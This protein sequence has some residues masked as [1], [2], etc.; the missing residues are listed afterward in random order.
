MSPRSQAA[1][2][3]EIRRLVS[4]L[5]DAVP[6]SDALASSIRRFRKGDILMR[7]GEVNNAIFIILEG[8]AQ[9]SKNYGT[10]NSLPVGIAEPGDFVG[11]I[12]FYSTEAVFS[13]V[14]ART[15]VSALCLTREEFDRL[16]D[17]N[18][19]LHGL[20]QQ[21]VISS[22]AERYRRIVTLHLEVAT[23]TREVEAERN[24]LHDALQE[25]GETRN[26]LIHQEK[27]AILGQLVAG[28]AHEINNPASAV[29]RSA[30]SLTEQ[31]P[32]LLRSGG[33]E[34]SSRDIRLL[35]RGVGRVVLSTGEERN[36]MN[37]LGSRYPHINRTLIR[38][39]AQLPPEDI[40]EL[41]DVLR[42]AAS[43]EGVAVLEGL[44]RN[45][46]VGTALRSLTISGERIGGIVRSLKAY[47]R[48]GT[49][50]LEPVDIVKGIQDTLLI[51]GNRL[52][53]VAVVLD[54]QA[55][56]AVMARSGELNQVWTNIILNACDAMNDQGTLTI[57]VRPSD[58][59]HVLVTI[60]DSGPGIPAEILPK[61]FQP[62]VTTKAAGG[63]F[64]LG[65]GLA[66][67]SEIIQKQGGTI[68]MANGEQGAVCTVT[69]PV[70]T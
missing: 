23:L 14:H 52:K 70:S 42:A 26:R 29:L 55:V 57:A 43:P 28:I 56:P 31:I 20:L 65:L 33:K 35:R 59:E 27:M 36:R 50:A 68:T 49:G 41:D 25:L 9:F 12:S 51:V 18:P 3:K 45:F 32:E 63:K 21:L 17:I 61:I 15:P 10:D 38:T 13:T 47:S 58:Q 44:L 34:E 67:S 62:N 40:H 4:A 19:G 16:P 7:E 69:L 37:D 54:L 39:L 8:K 5:R 11:L 53:D 6:G 46:E 2:H 1:A 30:E 48:A 22:L 64:G 60:A 66:I 24:Q